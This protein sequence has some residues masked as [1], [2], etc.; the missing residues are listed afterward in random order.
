MFSIEDR[1]RIRGLLVEKAR[2]DPIIVS[3]ALVGSTVTGGD[4]WSD[5]DL[6]F[7]VARG[8]PI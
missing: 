7:G 8:V 4:R 3:A 1:N 6:T 2:A 5:L